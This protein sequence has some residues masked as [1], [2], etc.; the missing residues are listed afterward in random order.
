MEL[1]SNYSKNVRPSP[2]VNVSL[3][4]D[5]FDVL[6]VDSATHALDVSTVIAMSWKEPRMTVSLED[7]DSDESEVAI[8]CGFIKEKMWRPSKFSR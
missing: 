7:G 4:V 8:E 3:H 6:E 1:T 2:L 5:L